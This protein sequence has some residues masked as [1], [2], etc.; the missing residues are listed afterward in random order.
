MSKLSDI[1]TNG[2]NFEVETI[3]INE[4][5]Y[6]CIAF[7]VVAISVIPSPTSTSYPGDNTNE[8]FLINGISR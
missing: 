5:H 6:L 4:K 3:E 1:E 2:K 8:C 7:S